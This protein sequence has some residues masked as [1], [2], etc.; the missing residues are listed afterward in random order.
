MAAERRLATRYPLTASAE[1]IELLADMHINAQISDL[2]LA[3]CYLYT[4]NPLPPGTPV[5]LRITHMDATFTAL[6]TV[7]YSAANLGMGI[8]FS[9]MELDQQKVLQKWV[10]AQRSNDT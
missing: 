1:I 10:D 8:K 4:I 6:G 2:S 9:T 3:G 7:T 5:R